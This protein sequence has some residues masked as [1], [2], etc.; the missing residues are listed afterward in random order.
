M[1]TIKLNVIY[2]FNLL[3]YQQ[4]LILYYI[5]KLVLLNKFDK[6]LQHYL[7]TSIFV[8]KWLTSFST[9]IRP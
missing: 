4:I 6:W 1:S 3:I 7:D 2:F 5:V 8:F 9:D